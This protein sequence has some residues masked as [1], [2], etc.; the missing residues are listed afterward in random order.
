MP[1]PLPALL[2]F[3]L[4]SVLF[5]VYTNINSGFT[6][7][8]W[9]PA[10]DILI[11]DNA[12]HHICIVRCARSTQCGFR[13]HSLAVRDRDCSKQNQATLDFYLDGAVGPSDPHPGVAKWNTVLELQGKQACG[14][15][16]ESS[17]GL[18]PLISCLP[19]VVQFAIGA[20]TAHPVGCP[21]SSFTGVRY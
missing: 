20:A 17:T 10:S 16:P 5:A 14:S 11:P 1:Q 21:M 15:L 4:S 7:S 18:P 12:W 13:T 3:G 8:Y 19:M 2:Q 9:D 6:A